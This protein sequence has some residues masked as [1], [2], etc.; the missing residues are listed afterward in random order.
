MRR[1]AFRRPLRTARRVGSDGEYPYG[2]THLV[3]GVPRDQMPDSTG[4]D[5]ESAD[6]T[7]TDAFD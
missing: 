2:L 7:V 6:D 1:K 3:R 4:P 5:I